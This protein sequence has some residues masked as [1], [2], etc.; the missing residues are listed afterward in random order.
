MSAYKSHV[1]MSMFKD[2]ETQLF[3]ITMVFKYPAKLILSNLE[4]PATIE[5]A[6]FLYDCEYEMIINDTRA[7]MYDYRRDYTFAPEAL[8]AID[9]HIEGKYGTRNPVEVFDEYQQVNRGHTV[10][11]FVKKAPIKGW[12]RVRTSSSFI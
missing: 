9:Y 12:K 3:Q 5:L 6:F 8:H 1:A 7:I 4:R 11:Y 2:F 10:V